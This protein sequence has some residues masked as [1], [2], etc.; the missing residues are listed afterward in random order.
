M[1][2]SHHI[3]M[4][5]LQIVRSYRFELLFMIEV[6]SCNFLLFT[7]KKHIT[8]RGKSMIQPPILGP[9]I[10]PQYWAAN[11]RHG[12]QTCLN[13]PSP[14]LLAILQIPSGRHP[15]NTARHG[16]LPSFYHRNGGSSNDKGGREPQKIGDISEETKNNNTNPSTLRGQPKNEPFV[17]L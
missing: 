6:T 13:L 9:N 14:R 4:E 5:L 15:R 1:W 11:P 10:G 7:S 3:D 17:N 8:S 16:D 12:Q 2:K